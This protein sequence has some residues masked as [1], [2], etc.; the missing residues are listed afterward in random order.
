MWL[1]WCHVTSHDD[2]FFFLFA[3]FSATAIEAALGSSNSLSQALQSSLA[4]TLTTS[5]HS[6]FME[7]VGR[8]SAGGDDDADDVSDTASVYTAASHLTTSTTPSEGGGDS[9]TVGSKE[10]TP[11][12][13]LECM[14]VFAR[15][16]AAI[17]CRVKDAALQSS[18]I[19]EIER[20][21]E[22]TCV[23]FCRPA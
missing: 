3:S 21:D 10:T 7:A 20:R 4:S 8:Q 6:M 1:L 22:T 14:L 15:I 9:P 18:L 17:A 16:V 19:G 5:L 11:A 2:S 23:W 13:K 12:L